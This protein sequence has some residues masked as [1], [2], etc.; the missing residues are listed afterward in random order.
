MGPS[1]F[2]YGAFV[3]SL[4]PL[5]FFVMVPSLFRY[6]VLVFSLWRLGYFD[7]APLLCRR[8]IT[9]RRNGANQPPYICEGA[10]MFKQ[11]QI[12]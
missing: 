11:P 6:D 8:E 12:G 1:L 5:R 4:W 2:R 3:I 9:K 10:T 7:M